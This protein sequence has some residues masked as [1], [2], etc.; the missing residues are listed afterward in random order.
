MSPRDTLFLLKDV[1][2]EL[3][4]SLS[5]NRAQEVKT[6]IPSGWA[7]ALLPTQGY[8][9]LWLLPCGCVCVRTS[10]VLDAAESH[11]RKTGAEAETVAWPS[12]DRRWQVRS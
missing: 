6:H 8:T 7:E 10:P 2:V 11:T 12:Q 4:Q 3:L 5:G 9:S 1:Q